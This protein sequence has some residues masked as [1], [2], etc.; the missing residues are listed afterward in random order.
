MI[1]RIANFNTFNKISLKNNPN[2]NY[3][4]NRSYGCDTV[5]FGNTSP[6]LKAMLN[7]QQGEIAD[8]SKIASDF[9]IELLSNVEALNQESLKSKIQEFLENNN[10]GNINVENLKEHPEKMAQGMARGCFTPKINNDLK[11]IKGGTIYISDIPQ[12]KNDKDIITSYIA[13]VCH[14]LTHALQY[15]NDKTGFGFDNEINSIDEANRI[16]AL[17]NSI[18]PKIVPE[19]QSY[20]LESFLKDYKKFNLSKDEAKNILSEIRKCD[21]PIFDKAVCIDDDYIAKAMSPNIPLEEKV[22]MI[23][24][25]TIEN[26]IKSNNVPQEKQK[27]IKRAILKRYIFEFQT[28]REAY[29]TAC[30]ILKKQYNIQGD[31]VYDMVPKAY[32]I[33]EDILSRKLNTIE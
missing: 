31:I 26:F 12:D 21:L 15:S 10:I 24:D 28:E 5:S 18:K 20:P 17:T 4:F 30:K 25:I 13:F 8:Y 3:N 32:K 23:A 11:G 2:K 16:F 29:N 6:I 22:N 9:G 1:S 14:E 33:V 7:K 27:S 19:L